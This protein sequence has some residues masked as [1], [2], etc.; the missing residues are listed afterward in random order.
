VNGNITL[1]GSISNATLANGALDGTKTG[2]FDETTNFASF[3]GITEINAG[4]AANPIIIGT[5]N[6]GFI[7]QLGNDKGFTVT[8][9]GNNTYT[10]GTS[11]L[12]AP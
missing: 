6:V 10:G 11:I 5:P 2:T 9:S 7:M 12:A 3:N 4:T 1:T 8:L